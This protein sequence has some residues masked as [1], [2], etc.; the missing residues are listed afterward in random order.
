MS[1][2]TLTALLFFLAAMALLVLIAV[3][4]PWLLFYAPSTVTEYWMP[5][6]ISLAALIAVI[7][8]WPTKADRGRWFGE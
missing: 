4:V 3:A 6:G 1:R 8:L 2:K 5:L 7:L